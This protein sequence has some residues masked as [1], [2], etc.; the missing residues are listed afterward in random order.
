MAIAIVIII[1]AMTIAITVRIL[2]N[3][4]KNTNIEICNRH[5]HH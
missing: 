2:I 5:H 1:I 4:I 3:E